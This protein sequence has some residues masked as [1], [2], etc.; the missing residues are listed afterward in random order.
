MIADA[1]LRLIVSERQTLFT[2]G[3]S[4]PRGLPFSVSF[5]FFVLDLL[6]FFLR[7]DFL[8]E[9]NCCLSQT[10]AATCCEMNLLEYG[11]KFPITK[12]RLLSYW[13][14]LG[15]GSEQ[16]MEV[17]DSVFLCLISMCKA[18][19]KRQPGV[20]TEFTRCHLNMPLACGHVVIYTSVT[21]PAS[22]GSEIN[23]ST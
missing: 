7:V 2:T 20:L 8:L 22:C 16:K 14:W 21:F 23:F 12:A 5:L 11:W 19:W 13:S 6:S 10:A 3:C 4:L 9:A 18:I 17:A 15:H 1:A